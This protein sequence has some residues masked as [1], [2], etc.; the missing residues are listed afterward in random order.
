MIGIIYRAKE[1][2]GASGHY[3]GQMNVNVKENSIAE[4]DRTGKFQTNGAQLKRTVL[5]EK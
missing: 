1:Q 4:K 5:A 3:Y 2:D